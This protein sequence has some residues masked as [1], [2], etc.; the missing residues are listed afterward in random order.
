MATSKEQP[1]TAKRLRDARRRGEVLHSADVSSTLVFAMVLLALWLGG[2]L[3][4]SLL[5]EL[6]QHATGRGLLT[7]PEQHFETLLLH[8]ARVLL[9]GTVP[10]LAVAALAGAAGSFAQVGGLAAWERVKPDASRL[11]PAQGLSRIFSTHN[12]VNLLKMSIK[13]LLLS[14]LIYV[15]IRGFLDSALSLGHARPVAILAA[16]SHM[17]V[18]C[19]AWATLIYALMAAVDYA[20]ERF[21]FIKR[22]R[23]SLDELRQEQRET[24]GDPLLMAR[25]R[26]VHFETV[27]ASLA[28]RVKAASA[29]VHSARVAVALQYLGPDDLPL[30]IARGE[31]ESAARIRQFAGESRV[32]M[33]FEPGLAER[34]YDEVPLDLRIAPNLFEPVA[35]ALRWAQGRS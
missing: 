23:M 14:L 3:L 30:V 22:H 35:T 29:V 1:P 34:L 4:Y 6:W 2:P 17:V 10:I 16:T 5:R 25:R 33:A 21:E 26:S 31:G 11:N 20:H 9:W 19:M 24:H 18:V 12:L 27:Y 28:D 32:P 8:T 15:V 7:Q 13:T